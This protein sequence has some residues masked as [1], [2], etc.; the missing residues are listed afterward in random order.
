[1]LA[2]G[3]RLDRTAVTGV[4][5]ATVLMSAALA[6][7]DALAAPA[8]RSHIGRELAGETPVVPL[9]ARK[10]AS[11]LEITATTI[12]LP[13][14]VVIVVPAILLVVR[15]GGLLARGFW[16]APGRRAALVGVAAGCVAAMVSNDTGIIV[17]APA[18]VVGAAAFYGPLMAP[19]VGGVELHRR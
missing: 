11:F 13:V 9:I 18:L 10:L 8:A 16:G 12:W 17:V 6:V 19:T 3:R 15:R 14:A 7:A 4:A 5:I 2:A 1:V